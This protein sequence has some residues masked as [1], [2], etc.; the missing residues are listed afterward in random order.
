MIDKPKIFNF[1][2]KNLDANVFRWA[3]GTLKPL[4]SSTIAFSGLF[5]LENDV[6]DSFGKTKANFGKNVNFSEKNENFRFSDHN[7]FS[8]T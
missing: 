8:V 5:F 6:W 3:P 1:F 4:G 2:G 7:F